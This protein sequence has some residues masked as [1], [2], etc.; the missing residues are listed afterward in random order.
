MNVYD[1]LIQRLDF[2]FGEFD[3]VVV[4]FSGGKDSGV[5]LAITMDYARRTGNLGRLAVYHMDYE[6]QYTA[7][8]EYVDRVFDA[9]P[10]EVDGYRVCLP[11]K[12]Q[13][14]TSMFQAYWQPWKMSEKSIWCRPMPTKH[15]IN[16]NNFP[17]NFDY[18]ISDYD[19]NI[20]LGKAVYPGK[21]VCFLVGIRTQE[22]LNR[23]RTM[24]R[25]MAVNEYKGMRYTTVITDNLVNAYPLFDWSVEDVWTANARFGYDYNKVYDLMYLAGV[26]LAKMR[27]ASPFNDCAQDALKLYKVIEPDTWGR[28]IGRVNGV[29]FTGLYGGTTA[30]GWKK[31]TKPPHFT[32]KQYMYFLLDTLPEETRKN[33][34]Y[35]LGVSIK[36]WRERGGCLS[37]ETIAELRAAGVD[38]EVLNDTNYKT[39]KRPVRME[40]LDD[41]DIKAFKEIPTYKRMC[42]C[43]IK[44]D[45]L[46]KYMGFSL[47]KDEMKRRKAIQDKYRDLL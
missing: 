35:K 31:V 46:C 28:L 3:K 33:Y 25:R 2:I 32:W 42:I 38:I 24:N 10:P 43:I 23:W 41:I 20:K 6:A 7:T 13:C 26:P 11:I 27:V 15:V 47:T 44:N 18:E 9:L 1:A 40:Y 8:T 21:K 45:H 16:E 22:S 4:S 36:F 39:T 34:L 30:M 29:N 37:D 19:F 17:W 14:S 12:A 5:L